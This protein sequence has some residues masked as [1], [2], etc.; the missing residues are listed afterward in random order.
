[1][2]RKKHRFY[3]LQRQ[4]RS[5]QVN[6]EMARINTARLVIEDILT[7]LFIVAVAHA[8]S[9]VRIGNRKRRFYAQRPKLH[10][11]VSSLLHNQMMQQIAN[12]QGGNGLN[13]MNGCARHEPDNGLG[14]SSEEFAHSATRS[15]RAATRDAERTLETRGHQTC[16]CR[17]AGRVRRNRQS[18]DRHQRTGYAGRS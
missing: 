9:I 4:A 1:M 11:K 17:A 6:F 15:A 3:K 8:Q 18:A 13:A 2:R 7:T 10:S 5:K 16:H 12:L 14:Q